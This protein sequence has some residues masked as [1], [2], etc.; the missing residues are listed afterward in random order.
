MNGRLV[1]EHITHIGV[2]DDARRL[3]SR[4]AA[5]DER[6]REALADNVRACRYGSSCNWGGRHFVVPSLV[7]YR[8]AWPEDDGDLATRVAFVLGRMTHNAA[9]AYFKPIEERLDWSEG[10]SS[11]EAQQ[12]QDAVVLR[13]VYDDATADPFAAGFLSRGLSEHPAAGAVDAGLAETYLGAAHQNRLL[14]FLPSSREF[15][16]V[17]ESVFA[18]TTDDG[19]ERR[20]VDSTDMYEVMQRLHSVVSDHQTYYVD[21]ERLVRISRDPDPEKT[22]HYLRDPDFYDA[23]DPAIEA[24][25]AIQ[26][27]AAPDD[28]HDAATADQESQY[29]Q[30]VASAYRRIERGAAFLV[31]DIGKAELTDHTGQ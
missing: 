13:E 20:T 11:D 21:F 14:T 1:S 26:R 10:L 25:R 24:A 28:V 30:C 8:E 31:G 4:S 17:L 5:F 29:G 27:G 18:P 7:R 12:Y 15:E 2:C 19:E 22:E 16:A 23:A 6:V 9:D 3:A